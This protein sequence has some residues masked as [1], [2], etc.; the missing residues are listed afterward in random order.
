MQIQLPRGLSPQL[1]SCSY[2]YHCRTTQVDV[3]YLL[4]KLLQSPYRDL[5]QILVATPV[6]THSSFP[7]VPPVL[8]QLD[9]FLMLHP[10][11]LTDS[12]THRRAGPEIVKT[13]KKESEFFL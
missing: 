11:N 9:T 2:T 6:S 1:T 8:T 5:A 7:L 10:T 4:Q 13:E 12:L 3:A